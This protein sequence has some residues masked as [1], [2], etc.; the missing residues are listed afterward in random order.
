MAEIYHVKLEKKSKGEICK[1]WS[2]EKSGDRKLLQERRHI[3]LD[4]IYSIVILLL[5]WIAWAECEYQ[6]HRCV[7]CTM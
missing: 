7:V 6:F 2:F 1:V 5:H 3:A 4:L